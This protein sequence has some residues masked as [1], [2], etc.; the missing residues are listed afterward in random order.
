MAGR[1]G[2]AGT[3]VASAVN[4]DRSTVFASSNDSAVVIVVLSESLLKEAAALVRPG[5]W[6][7]APEAVFHPARACVDWG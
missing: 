6:G 5:L 3:V 7:I 4:D 2:R 1:A